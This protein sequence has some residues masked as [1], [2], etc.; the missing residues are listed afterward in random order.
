MG[1]NIDMTGVTVGRL[2]VLRLD[3]KGYRGRKTWLCTCTCGGTK[4]V[5]TASLRDGKTKSCGCLHL[6]TLAKRSV[7]HGDSGSKEHRIWCSMWARCKI[8]S[9]TGY[10]Q[11]GAR[12]ITVCNE[13]KDFAEF[14]RD[15][16]RCP[17]GCSL[18]RINND[19]GY[20]KENCSWATNHEQACNTSR[21][22]WV[23]KDGVLMLAAEVAKQNMV[24]YATYK[25]RL[26]KQKWS[27]EEACGLTKRKNT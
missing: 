4:L 23:E 25:S 14:L 27:I 12:G 6:E 20:S 15:M 21:T 19:S 22:R 9:A 11:Y 17:E 3:S 2:T 1:K 26:Y 13:W 16:G 18:N 5:S 10:A 8:K 7:T 24:P